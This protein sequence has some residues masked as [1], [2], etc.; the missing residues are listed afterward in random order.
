MI[1]FEIWLKCH[2]RITVF[3]AV[4]QHRS[5]LKYS[6]IKYKISKFADK[7]TYLL[8]SSETFNELNSNYCKN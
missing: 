3:S 6:Q 4:T 5:A 2:P 1:V 7:T 8:I